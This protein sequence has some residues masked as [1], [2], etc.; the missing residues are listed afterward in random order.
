MSRNMP[1]PAVARIWEGRTRESIAAMYAVLL[2]LLMATNCRLVLSANDSDDVALRISEARERDTARHVDRW[3]DD[4]PAE[5]LHLFQDGEWVVH[6]DIED[7]NRLALP[8]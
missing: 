8:A 7:G 1:R 3:H 2:V 4:T 6:P 5:R